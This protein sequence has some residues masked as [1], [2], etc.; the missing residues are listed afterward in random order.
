MCLTYFCNLTIKETNCILQHSLAIPVPYK[1]QR[2]EM[3]CTIAIYFTASQGPEPA[4]ERISW[5]IEK[6][7]ELES[8]EY[9]RCGP[10]LGGRPARMP[11]I[12]RGGERGKCLMACASLVPR[13]ETKENCV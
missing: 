12:L 1:I 2:R 8:I 6:A 9:I 11:L 5:N 13:D 4:G 10:P 3:N 7:T